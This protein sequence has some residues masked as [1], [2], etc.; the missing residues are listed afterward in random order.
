MGSAGE[1]G[2]AIFVRRFREVGEGRSS[3]QFDHILSPQRAYNRVVAPVGFEHDP[4]SRSQGR[5]VDRV[6]PRIT[7]DGD[8]V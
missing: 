3:W 7:R 4:V 5:D 6:V 8:G 2:D 1:A